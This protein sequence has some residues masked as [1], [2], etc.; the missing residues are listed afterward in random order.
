MKFRGCR[1]L[2][3]FPVLSCVS[4]RTLY[5]H[6]SSC[7]GVGGGGLCGLRACCGVFYN[8]RLPLVLFC[9]SLYDRVCLCTL[10]VNTDSRSPV[11]LPKD[12]SP[13]SPPTHP[14][15]PLSQV[16]FPP[17]HA[18]N[19]FAG[20]LARTQEVFKHSRVGHGR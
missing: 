12:P 9:N 17:R 3:G 5:A 15:T 7:T 16:Y 4:T 18:H 8:P 2:V 13:S 19:S 10:L 1:H 6:T 20:T 14:S 11:S